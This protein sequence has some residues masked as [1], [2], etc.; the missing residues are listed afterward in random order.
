MYEQVVGLH[1][2]RAALG[3]DTACRA[4]AGL[5][6]SAPPETL[7]AGSAAP[8]RSSCPG[9]EGRAAAASDRPAV[10]SQCDSSWTQHDG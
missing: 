8:R 4:G 6:S 9:P 3:V 7:S 10:V 2:V 1:L 5:Q